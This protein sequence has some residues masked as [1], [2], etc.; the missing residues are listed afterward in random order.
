MPTPRRK[1]QDADDA[2]TQLAAARAAGVPNREW[3]AR[4]GICA[5][6]LN[7]WAVLRAR[8]A[9]C[10]ARH[11]P[12]FVE[13]MPAQPAAPTPLRLHVDDIVIEVGAGVDL[14]L[15]TRVLRAVRAC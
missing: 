14:D 3:A 5:R 11:E 13:L 10:P 9:K 12:R 1:I 2:T 6:S 15:L 8:R 4:N 7:M